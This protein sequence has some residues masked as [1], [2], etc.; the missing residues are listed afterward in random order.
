MA[1]ARTTFLTEEYPPLNTGA[2]GTIEGIGP[3]MLRAAAGQLNLTLRADQLRLT[4]WTDAYRTAL[5]R[6]DTVVFS[7]ART[8]DR[9]DLFQWAGPIAR[10]QYVVLADRNR[11]VAGDDL[12]RYRIATIRDDTAATY[13]HEAGVT[14]SSILYETDP[15]ALIAAIGDGRADALA[16]PLLPAR[17]LLSRYDG[18][19]DRFEVV[20]LL[21]ER[22][23]YFA[24]NRNVSPIVVRAF[25]QSLAALKT[26]RDAAG[27][28]P[29][30]RILYRHVGVECSTGT[31]NLTG[32]MAV[33]NLTADRMAADAPGTFRAINAG[34]APYRDPVDPEVYAFVY[35]TNLTMVAHGSNYRLVGQ[36]FRGRT[37][38]AGTAFRDEILAT[39][40]AKGSGWVDYVYANM[41]R[42]ASRRRRPTVVSSGAATGAAISSARERSGTVTPEEAPYR[43]RRGTGYDARSEMTARYGPTRAAHPLDGRWPGETLPRGG[44]GGCRPGTGSA[45]PGGRDGHSAVVQKEARLAMGMAPR[46]APGG[47]RISKRARI[48]GVPSR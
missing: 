48:P 9:E 20:R 18:E 43:P 3:D 46:Q 10:L 42:A 44:P 41:T 22:D 17:A 2:N 19:P 8:A 26:E 11:T 15:A 35:D 31:A 23:M 38:V 12:A 28:A 13:L 14:D 27:V 16:Y 37:D 21:G 33:V 32:A 4:T 1:L 29:Y 39:A 47:T 34:L 7:T 24:F 30:E 45:E 6:N 40:T 36:N 25:N 5:E